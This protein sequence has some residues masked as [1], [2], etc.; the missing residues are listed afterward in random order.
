MKG[1]VHLQ[2]MVRKF[3]P[4]A[5]IRG[6]VVAEQALRSLSRGAAGSDVLHAAHQSLNGDPHAERG[7]LGR[8][9]KALVT[10]CMPGE[11]L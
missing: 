7:F 8:L 10:S 5:T 4:M 11:V 2:A 9:Q 1:A 3:E 6:Q